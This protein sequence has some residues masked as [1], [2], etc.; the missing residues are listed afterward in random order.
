MSQGSRSVTES[1]VEFLTIFLP[2][3]VA[4]IS[5]PNMMPSAV[6][7]AVGAGW[8]DYPSH[9]HQPS[10]LG[11]ISSR[12]LCKHSSGP[13]KPSRSSPNSR[14]C[15]PLPPS[16][17]DPTRQFVVEVDVSGHKGRL[18]CPITQVL[19]WCHGSRL[20]RQCWCVWRKACTTLLKFS[21]SY[22]QWANHKCCPAFPYQ[23]RPETCTWRSHA[24]SLHHISLVCSQCPKCSTLWLYVSSSPGSCAF[25]L[26]S[27]IWQYLQLYKCI[28][29]SLYYIYVS[30]FKC[31]RCANMP[32]LLNMKKH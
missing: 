1:A 11:K 7:F 14:N 32:W 23:G 29:V 3:I 17:L 2:S 9:P 22:A 31:C 21:I 16:Q 20:F 5:P 12:P 30:L 25:I 24:R 13:L 28:T 27:Y 6:G 26:C 19:Q 10:L 4:G 15:S 8:V 18:F